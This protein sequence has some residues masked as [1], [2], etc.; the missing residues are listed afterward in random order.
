[1][2]STISFKK[3]HEKYLSCRWGKGGCDDELMLYLEDVGHGTH[4]LDPSGLKVQQ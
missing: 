3:T 2:S 1:M 4:V